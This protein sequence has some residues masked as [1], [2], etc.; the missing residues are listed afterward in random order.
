MSKA[1]DERLLKK[2]QEFVRTVED[3]PE[4]RC[5]RRQ[6]IVKMQDAAKRA[7]DETAKR[8]DL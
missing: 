5:R 4:R 8:L 3:I 2:A 6:D 1:T 7:V